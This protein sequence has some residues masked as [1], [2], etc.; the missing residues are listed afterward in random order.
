[1]KKM[2]YSSSYTEH[3]S[4]LTLYLVYVFYTLKHVL[5]E[6]IDIASLSYG[7]NKTYS[8]KCVVT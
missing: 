1:M 4:I 2:A 8:C 7:M 6:M 3:V 5:C